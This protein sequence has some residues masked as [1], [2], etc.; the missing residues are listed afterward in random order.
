MSKSKFQTVYGVRIYPIEYL[1]NEELTDSDLNYLFDT[2]SLLYSIIIGMYR[3]IGSLK[4]NST[5]IKEAKSNNWQ[6]KTTWTKSQ[7]LE[8]ENN[9]AQVIKN[10]YSYD[11]VVAKQKAEWYMIMYGLDVK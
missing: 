4:R 11:N 6:T 1:M 8:Y 2:K 5:I 7:L 10:L 3:S 9:I